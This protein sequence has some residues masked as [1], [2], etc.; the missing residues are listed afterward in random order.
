[1][2]F[3]GNAC[4]FFSFVFHQLYQPISPLSYTKPFLLSA[5]YFE[6]WLELSKYLGG[7]KRQKAL[8]VFE[9]RALQIGHY[10]GL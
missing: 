8:G 1:M 9:D 6:V 10:R 3:F 7:G 5:Y 4:L 2:N